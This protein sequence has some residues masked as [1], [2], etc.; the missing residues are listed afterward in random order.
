[1]VESGRYQNIPREERICQICT[2]NEIETKHHFLTSC[3][4]YENVRQGFLEILAN[5]T[6]QP[7]QDLSVDLI[8]STED[9]KIIK[10][11][12]FF[13]PNLFCDKG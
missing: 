5:D 9:V 12:K 6:N 2:S 13:Y 4:A 8:R 10:L 3:D 11:S 7:E 1:M